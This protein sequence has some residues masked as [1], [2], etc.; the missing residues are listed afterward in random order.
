MPI[1]QVKATKSSSTNRQAPRLKAVKSRPEA[2]LNSL[3]LPLDAHALAWIFSA[4]R[5]RRAEPKPELTSVVAKKPTALRDK[6]LLIISFLILSG[7]ALMSWQLQPDFEAMYVQRI[8]HW[9]GIS[10]IAMGL[11]LLV[12]KLVFLAYLGIQFLRYRP[13]IGIEDTHLPRITVIVPAFNEGRQVWATLQSL[14]ESNYPAEKLQLIAIDDGSEDDTWS[15]MKYAKANLGDRVAI[16]QQPHNQGK[17]HALYRGFQLGDGEIFVTVDSDSIV[18]TD[19]LRNLVS[20]FAVDDQC[21]AVAGNV[22]VLNKQEAII[23]RMLNVSFLFSFEFI[24]S[25]QSS[26]GTV[27]CTPGALAA[28]RR[29][30]VMACLPEWINQQFMGKKSDIGEDRAMTNMILKQGYKVRFQRNAKVL[31]NIPENYRGLYKM[32]IRWE[33]SNVRENLMMS[34]FAFSNFRRG[35]KADARFLLVNQWLNMLMTY[36][37]LFFMF[38]FLFTQPGLFISATLTSVLF[39]STLPALFF[40]RKKQSVEA[41]WAYVYGL[42]YTFGLFWIGPYA[43]ATAGRRGWLTRSLADRQR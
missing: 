4:E 3:L 35:N 11:V 37:A 25:A 42:F 28:Y 39:F 20:P 18:E 40:A 30:A 6:L 5:W 26:S 32:F 21:G 19:T 10:L 29:E 16:Y 38:Y 15:W 33:R 14:V 23:P 24:R 7:G 31:T 13:V 2:R 12:Y 9:G 17:R 8:Q 34:K 36:P 22:R 41:G 1:A 27:L 43:L